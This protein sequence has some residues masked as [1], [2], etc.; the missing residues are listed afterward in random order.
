MWEKEPKICSS[1][2]FAGDMVSQE[3]PNLHVRADNL[4]VPRET[5]STPGA[6]PLS[7]TK[8]LLILLMDVG[9]GLRPAIEPQ[10]M[11]HTCSMGLR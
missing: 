10:K 6:T 8:A 4:S 7:G 3:T 9:A 5:L 1:E 11:G 2:N